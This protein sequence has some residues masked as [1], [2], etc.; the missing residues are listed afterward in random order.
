MIYF[1]IHKLICIMVNA[2][3]PTDLYEYTKN[4][5]QYMRYTIP[6]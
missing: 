5:K 1:S 4:I 2:V 6:F 3:L